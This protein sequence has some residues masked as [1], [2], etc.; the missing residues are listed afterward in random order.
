MSDD[1]SLFKI[2]KFLKCKG[3]LK[4]IDVQRRFSMNSLKSVLDIYITHLFFFKT[5]QHGPQLSD[6]RGK[7]YIRVQNQYLIQN[8]RKYLC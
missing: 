5:F 8:I 2:T 7:R 1:L 4:Y 3:G 6:I